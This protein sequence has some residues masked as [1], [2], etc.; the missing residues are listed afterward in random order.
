MLTD[1]TFIIAEAGVN[2]NGNIAIAKSLIDVAVDAGADAVKFQT[3]TADNSVSKITKKADYQKIRTGSSG[4]QYELIKGL[5][6]DMNDH[7]ELIAYCKKSNIRFLSSPFD[8][9][10]IQLLD[11]LGL[12]IFKIPSGEI[13]NL[14]YLE[15]LGKLNKEIIISSGMSNLGEIE[16]ALEVLINHGTSKEKITVLHVNTDY[17]TSFDEVNLFAMNTIKE[18]FKIKVGYSDHTLGIE[19]PIAAVAM[20]AEV[21]EKHFTLNKDAEGPDHKASLSPDELKQMI[22]CIRNIEKSLGTGIKKPSFS[23]INNMDKVRKSLVAIKKIKRGEIFNKN[24]LGIKRPGNG[25]SPMR[26]N[27]VMGKK[28]KRDFNEDELIEI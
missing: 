3:F 12:S 2:H 8:I 14:P 15:I 26:W 9:P 20:G 10:S 16:A 18:A 1:K 7:Q 27:E 17:P 25:I 23:E 19:V 24:N 22:Y 21:I 13:T 6:L 28:A 5:E 4:S 11:K